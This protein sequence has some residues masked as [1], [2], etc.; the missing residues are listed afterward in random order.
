MTVETAVRDNPE[1]RSL[2][3]KWE[4]ML[5]RPAQESAL[6]DPLFKY[7]AMDMA[8]SG[9]WPNTNEKWFMVEQ[10]FP[11]FGKRGL[12]EG[13]ARKDAEAMQRELEG[14]TRDIAMRVKEAYYDLHAVQQVIA[15]TGT[16]TELLRSM[17]KVAEAMYTT[18]KRSQQDV[19]KATTEI[20]L[21]KQRLLE[22]E[23]QEN[24]LK[25]KLNTLL[26]R[27]ADA[28]LVAAVTPPVIELCATQEALFGLALTN[29]PEIKAA[30]IQVERAALEQK[31]MAKETLPNYTL[32]LEY[33]DIANNDNML[34]FTVGVELPVWRSKYR[35]GVREAEKMQASSQA[36]HEVAER[37]S[38]LDVQDASFKLQTSRRRLEL[39]RTELIPQAEARF[40][41]SEA[42]YQTGAVDFMDLLESQRFLLN[43]RVMAA[44]EAGTVGM[45]FARL[46][47]AVGVD[48]KDGPTTKQGK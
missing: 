15:I 28:P 48:L 27:R 40:R 36:A 1:L 19:L 43:V 33:R 21:L 37:N 35:A 23:A 41:A 45:Q 22:L 4:A 14:M 29:R 30:Q 17:A 12:R 38:A 44:M 24:T 8:G 6:P 7:S 31:M 9:N 26:N 39:Y 25:A 16:D 11:W 20:T 5:E 13:I 10:T 18:G 32:G 42:G 47:Q 2:R 3:A 46:E 34:M